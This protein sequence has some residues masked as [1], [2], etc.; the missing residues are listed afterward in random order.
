MAG[1]KKKY[2]TAKELERAVNAYFD[3]ISYREPAVVATPTGEVDEN[4]H[5]KYTTMLLYEPGEKPG[6][7][8]KPVTM[9]RWLSPPNMAGLRLRL[10]ISKETWSNYGQDEELRPVVERTRARME[11]YWC[12]K[13]EGKSAQ[14][15][16]FAL[17][18]C[19]GW[20]ERHEVG[21]DQPTRKTLE[22]M[23]LSQL[24]DEELKE[25]ADQNMNGEEKT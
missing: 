11:D 10:G 7:R 14:G 21:L 15:A 17:S 24:S 8:G 6:M 12:G 16:K 5:V 13:L 23:D 22:G 18:S 3:S 4:G 1:R 19:Y 2:R 20:R 25:L 9:T